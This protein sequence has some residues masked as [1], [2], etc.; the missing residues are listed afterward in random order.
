[1]AEMFY[2]GPPPGG[3][4]TSVTMVDGSAQAKQ[5]VLGPCVLIGPAQKGLPDQ[6]TAF[7]DEAQATRRFGRPLAD[8]YLGEAIRG[9]FEEAKGAG[10]L[11]G[12][13]VVAS[14]N[15]G[16]STGRLRLYDRN[17]DPNWH[18]G[19]RSARLR[20]IVCDCQAASPGEWAGPAYY[21]GG[22]VADDS[23][24]ISGQDF[25]TAYTTLWLADEL[26]G[27]K[28][29]LDGHDREYTILGNTAAGVLSLDG[30]FTTYTT[31]GG[32][33]K[34]RIYRTN[35]D[36]DGNPME[37]A[38]VVGD[39]GGQPLNLSSMTL[40]LDRAKQI[41][42]Y[43][44]LD[45][46]DPAAIEQLIESELAGTGPNEEL[47]LDFTV[48][49]VGDDSLPEARPA[50]WAGIPE[51]KGVAAAADIGQA[52]TS[53]T[54][55]TVHFKVVDLI[56]QSGSGEAELDPDSI[57]WGASPMPHRLTLTFADATNFTVQAHDL[58]GK[59]IASELPNGAKNS[60]YASQHPH[61]AGFKLTS[62]GTA[63]ADD[64]FVL[65]FRPFPGDLAKRGARVYVSAFASAG[66]DPTKGYN[67][68]GSAEES[69]TLATNED[70]AAAFQP[71]VPPGHAGTTDGP[72]DVSAPKTFI[73]TKTVN[74]IA[75]A[76]VTLTITGG[77]MDTAADVVA[78]LEAQDLLASDELLFYADDDDHV[79]FYLAS[80]DYGDDV[81]IATSGTLMA[82]VGM[83]AATYTGTRGVV[84]RLEYAEP[85]R[86]ARPEHA[87]VVNGDYT[88]G[89]L[90]VSDT[91]PLYQ[92]I[93]GYPGIV[94]IALPGV[95]DAALHQAA[96]DFCK[97]VGAWFT[98]DL[99]D[100]DT[101]ASE[102]AA[103]KWQ[104]DNIASERYGIFAW[105]A[106][107]YTGDGV[108]I[109]A[110]LR[111]IP[112]SGEI[113]GARV[114][115]A[116]ERNA[117]NGMGWHKAPGG[118]ARVRLSPR[119]KRLDTGAAFGA[120][121]PKVR[122]HVLNNAGLLPIIQE[123]AVIYLHGDQGRNPQGAGTFWLHKQIT[124]LQISAD[125]RANF[126]D[127][128]YDVNRGGAGSPLELKM[129][130]KAKMIL[131]RY[132]NDGA[133]DILVDG[134]PY[135]FKNCVVI[136][137]GEALN[138]QAVRDQGKRI[139]SVEFRIVNTTKVVEWQLFT[140]G[141]SVAFA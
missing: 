14:T 114:R 133:L 32:A 115:Y 68:I 71:S 54:G 78:L 36:T 134:Q 29:R 28:F 59:Q 131:R 76:P 30:G 58:N 41:K 102:E 98:G 20:A 122:D 44:Q 64:V 1:M 49:T 40:V 16:Q 53:G 37:L 43:E 107:G 13:R 34:F 110:K 24:A 31:T 11:Y 130:A 5:G 121:Q 27:A 15:L 87:G 46:T 51:P 89:P 47:Q 136:E 6:V 7:V 81:T 2:S 45:L 92:F 140:D 38:V 139:G 73:Y 18:A 128:L 88:S 3:A 129:V 111:K 100:G 120:A 67:V 8:D 141:I 127:V 69:L 63:V 74:G 125:L 124:A 21:F 118:V 94:H 52:K 9:F 90:A 66:N 104:R 26:K 50:N 135:L 60:T 22:S 72:Y 80:G 123:G 85:M 12:H 99:P 84:A 82:V 93:L 112:L 126:G 96:L 62:A 17:P 57:T 137:A 56:R 116:N 39:D 86:N 95:V 48:S 79:A 75:A 25:D 117:D 77:A 132:F 33:T 108:I 83:T 19:V 55:K 65:E 109:P 103:A 10:L 138:P 35:T 91:N 105:P 42:R 113:M 23:A 119:I 97:A 70:L 106:W 101:L 61:I 4:G